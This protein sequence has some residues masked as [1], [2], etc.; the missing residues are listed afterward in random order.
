LADL[1]LRGSFVFPEMKDVKTN[2]FKKGVERI[3]SESMVMTEIEIKDLDREE[4]VGMPEALR[5][6]FMYP[7]AWIK[8]QDAIQTEN[9]WLIAERDEVM[10][11]V[12]T[13][14][15]LTI[16]LT[17]KTSIPRDR[18]LMEYFKKAEENFPEYLRK[19]IN[20]EI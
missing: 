9:D 10:Q 11:Y 2:Y 12:K 18:L 19:E 16:Y 4:H 20:V 6:Q 14:K 15:M 5:K 1:A 3:M 7:D 13:L 17:G 8:Q